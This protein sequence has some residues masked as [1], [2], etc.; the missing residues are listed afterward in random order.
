MLIGRRLYASPWTAL[1]LVAAFT[2]RHQITRTS[3]N[4]FE[5]YFH[6]RMLAFG[7]GLLAVAAFVHRRHWLALTLAV[8]AAAVHN[9]TGLWF[10]LLI[11][12]AI[13]A[14]EPAW[15]RMA[16]PAAVAGV[17][18]TAWA[19]DGPLSRPPGRDGRRLAAG[20]GGE[21][22][23]LRQRVAAVGVGGQSGD[24][25]R[26]VGRAP[27]ARRRTAAPAPKNARSPGARPRSW[28][29]S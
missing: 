15:R 6:P 29:S 1:A 13:V 17:A 19:L 24:A 5:P 2:M 25:R 8:A 14:L 10:A 4:T 28:P 16:M 22:L 9:T 26:A 27:V 3:A 11:G 18:V 7:I 12:A 20:G 23:A 21:V